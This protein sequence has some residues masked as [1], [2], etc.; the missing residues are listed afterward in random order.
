MGSGLLASLGPGMTAISG[1]CGPR[2]GPY[3]RRLAHRGAN[4]LGAAALAGVDRV[5]DV[6]GDGTS[7]MIDHAPC[8]NRTRHHQRRQARRGR[9]RM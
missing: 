6:G 7:P 5:F 3:R 8:A 2:I 1:G 9:T 4:E